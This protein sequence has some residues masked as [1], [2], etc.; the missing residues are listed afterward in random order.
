M[1]NLFDQS[2]I[3]V[4]SGFN[5]PLSRTPFAVFAGMRIKFD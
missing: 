1:Q 2:Y 4:N 5:P 3:A